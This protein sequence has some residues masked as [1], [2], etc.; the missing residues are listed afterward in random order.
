MSDIEAFNIDNLTT[1]RLINLST[2]GNVGVNDQALIAGLII[3][4]QARTVVVRT[5]GPALARFGVLNAVGDTMLKIIDQKDGS[6]VAENDDWQTDP[7]NGRLRT[8]L[9]AF[10]PTDGREAALVVT[11]PP[12]AYTA[13]VSA[14]NAAGVGLV[15]AFEV[16]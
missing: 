6:I 13:I 7:R 4:N 9:A 5:Q 15:E 12:G 8:D 14:K 11:L 1:G 3:A 2:R 16:N 10:A